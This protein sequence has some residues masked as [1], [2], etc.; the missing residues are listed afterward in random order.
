MRAILSRLVLLIAMA[1]TTSGQHAF[2]NTPVSLIEGPASSKVIAVLELFTSQGCSSCPPAD[3]LLHTYAERDELLALSYFV[4]IWDK[5]GWK[6]TLAHPRFTR[7]QKEYSTVRHDNQIYTPQLVIN[8]R[9]HVVGSNKEMIDAEI[10]KLRPNSG[11]LLDVDIG[12]QGEHLVIS[13]PGASHPVVAEATIWLVAYSPKVTVDVNV[14]ENR[15]KSMTYA[16]VVRDITPVGVWSGKP[17]VL[18]LPRSAA[19][20]GKSTR[21][22]VIVQRGGKAQIIGAAKL[23]P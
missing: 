4:D 13:L 17:L 14:G 20:D 15:G 22:A 9:S 21:C 23:A 18:R 6:D 1:V 11:S 7:R 2:A 10:E 19:G 12:L 16:N 5:L 3:R 8:A